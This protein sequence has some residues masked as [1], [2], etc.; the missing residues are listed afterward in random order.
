[1]THAKVLTP[2]IGSV[3]RS[4][5]L[6]EIY[7]QHARFVWKTL[8][9]MG[10]DESHLEDVTQDVF[11]VVHRRLH[12][13]DESARMTTWL[14]GIC[15]KVAAA[16]RRRAW[17]RREKTVESPPERS[18]QPG[19]AAD[20]FMQVQEAKRRIRS[21]LDRM[22]VDKRAVFLM[23]EIEEMSTT[24]IAELLGV[25][26][27]TVHSRLHAAREQFRLVLSRLDARAFRGGDR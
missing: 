10:V 22:D 5:E 14:Y 20:D 3:D 12:T 15:L 13:F 19:R 1:V 23:Y 17:Q 2:G 24:E 25:P 11:V 9:R 4:L 27:G 16:W 26:P 6:V 18:S 21:V 7:R 8:A